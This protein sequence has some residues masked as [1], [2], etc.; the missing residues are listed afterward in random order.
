M[1]THF[2]IATVLVSLAACGGKGKGLPGGDKIPGG[3]PGG[4][5]GESGM[6]DPNTCGNYAGSE[7]GA[8]LKAFL[9]A[10][11]DL[12]KRSQETVDVVRS[13]CVTM[14][15]EL[16]MSDVD[17]AEGMQVKD[18]LSEG[19]GRLQ[20]P[21]EGAPVHAQHPPSKDSL[22]SAAVLQRPTLYGSRAEGLRIKCRTLGASA[23]RRVTNSVSGPIATARCATSRR[24]HQTQSPNTAAPRFDSVPD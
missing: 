13:S 1:R 22:T 6:V 7:A 15:K 5:G 19:L 4:L 24:G 18:V 23:Q 11:T 14:G 3:A 17:F 8:R 20:P 10:I 2:L 12:Q 16:G 9:T 21:S